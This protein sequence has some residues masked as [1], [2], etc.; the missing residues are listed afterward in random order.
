MRAVFL[1]K[2]GT[3]VEDL[4][5]NVD[6]RR[7]RLAV[8]AGP[9]LRLLASLGYQLFVVSNQSGVARGLFEESALGPVWVRLNALLHDEGV[10]VRAIACCPHHPEGVVERYAIVCNCR[11][12]EPGM[13]LKL[14]QEHDI[15]L[16]A[17]WMIGDIL[18]DVEAGHKA[19][20][21]SVLIDNGNETL[22]DISPAR[23]PELVATDLY[24]AAEAIRTWRDT[25]AAPRP[26][27]PLAGPLA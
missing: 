13:F 22:W 2:D 20:C 14:A 21:R 16:H 1:D 7:I 26:G 11:K 25:V 24:H 10:S 17:S 4:P 9:A 27:W 5:F 15:D 19:G 18:D 23:V 8:R 6:P 12:P 3:L